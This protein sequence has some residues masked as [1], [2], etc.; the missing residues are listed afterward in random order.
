[1]A[2]DVI[3]NEDDL[4]L[5]TIDN[6]Y[7]PK[8]HYDEWKTWDEDNGHYTEEYVAR[9][10][11][12]EDDFDVDDVIKIDTLLDKVYQDILEHDVIGVYMLI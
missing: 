10:L 6:P 7:N 12:M 1:M 2:E 3:N 9:L 5:T 11:E 8:T 4:M